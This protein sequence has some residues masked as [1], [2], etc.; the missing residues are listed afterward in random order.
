MISYNQFTAGMVILT[1]IQLFF[2]LAERFVNI[3][4]L[5]E[6]SSKWE[7]TLVAKYFLLIIQLCYSEFLIVFFFPYSSDNFSSNSYM[8]IFYIFNVLTF[9]LSAL[10]IR[11]GIDQ[12]SKGFMDKYTWY[13]GFIYMAFRAVPFLF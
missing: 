10:Q 3:A 2:L 12:Q 6:Y 13:N 5:K 1:L 9:L 7:L 11:Y 4:D 8:S